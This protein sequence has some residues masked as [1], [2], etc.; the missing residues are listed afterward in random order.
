MEMLNK[1][2][3]RRQERVPPI[4]AECEARQQCRPI[5]MARA[6]LDGET[7][8][9]GEAFGFESALDHGFF[10]LQVDRH[11]DFSAADI[12][13]ETFYRAPLPG[14]IDYRSLSLDGD[15]QG[16]S[17]RPFDQWENF[18]IE[19]NN[20]GKIPPAVA[21][22]GE[23]MADMG[24]AVLRA[25]LE[26]LGIDSAHWNNV[27]GGLTGGG[28][29]RMLAFNHFRSERMMRGCKMHR[30]SGWVTVLRSTEPGLLALIDDELRAINPEPGHVILN[31]GSSI[32]VLTGQM[33]RPVR[34]NIHGVTRTERRASGLDRHSY[35]MFL[36]S[37]LAGMIYQMRD[38]VPEAVQSVA[39]F[40]VQEV[41][42]TYDDN[43]DVI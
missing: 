30:D 7:L 26:R 2:T 37:D 24:V 9:F 20:W 43:D 33:P 5:T 4:P 10:L 22:I 31:F 29:H 18:Y 38:G 21:A 3:I 35:A 40:A 27:T 15:Y 14:G 32:E 19:H 6:V 25:V 16:Y 1:A 39:E 13:A 11:V 8:R 23:S 28:G 41:Q 12:F 34:A 17:D 36:D 42:R